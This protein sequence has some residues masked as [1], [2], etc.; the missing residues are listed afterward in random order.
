MD[1]LRQL[2]IIRPDALDFPIN[3]IGCGGIGSPTALALAKMGCTQLT[4]YDPDTVEDHNLPNQLFPV[5]S[6]G[7]PKV[8]VLAEVL[9]QFTDCKPVVVQRAV[10]GEES[11]QG[12]CI[13]AVD[14]MAARQDLWRGIHRNLAV[15]L[16]ID[17]RMGGEVGSIFSVHPMEP[18]EIAFY[19]STLHD[20][21]EAFQLPCTAQA[22]IYNALIMA[23]LI[24]NQ[25]KKFA[26]GET[27]DYEIFFNLKNLMF[28]NNKIK[29]T[30]TPR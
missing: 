7:R 24:A 4:L 27:L 30:Q 17:A 16:L 11:L 2:D 12:V 5:T 1:F 26:L 14:T 18:E 25:V 15:P 23:S 3:I 22:I 9:E 28:L 10:T 19:E 8:E 21:D 20:D 6:L 13:L 29:T